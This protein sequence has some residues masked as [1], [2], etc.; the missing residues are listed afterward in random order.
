MNGQVLKQGEKPQVPES[1]LLKLCV[2]VESAF[3][4]I[5]GAMGTNAEFDGIVRPIAG[6]IM[7]LGKVSDAVLKA[8]VFSQA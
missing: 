8:Q 2:K 5:R 1:E 4:V 7:G 6:L 3:G